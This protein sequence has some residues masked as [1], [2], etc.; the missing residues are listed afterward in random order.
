[1][2]FVTTERIAIK[3]TGIARAPSIAHLWPRYLRAP[4]YIPEEGRS[5]LGLL[6]THGPE[7]FVEELERLSQLGSAWAS[8]ALGYICLLP[9]RTGE[10]DIERAISLCQ[11]HADAGDPYASFVLAWGLLRKGKQVLALRYMTRAARRE[12]PPAT[13][14]LVTYAWLLA[15]WKDRDPKRALGLLR[16]VDRSGHKAAL[17][18]RCELYRSGRFGITRFMLGYLFAPFA[19]LRYVLAMWADPVSA[20]V[21]VLRHAAPPFSAWP[22]KPEKSAFRKM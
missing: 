13:L 12:F 7:R 11:P 6:R 10:R 19:Y 14:D 18:W 1:M 17:I 15:G 16:R 4:L 5:K 20:R 3:P 9:G 22:S 2:W 8:G 21:L